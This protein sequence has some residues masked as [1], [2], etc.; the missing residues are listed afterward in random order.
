MRTMMNKIG[1]TRIALISLFALCGCATAPQPVCPKP[2]AELLRPG[3]VDFRKRLDQIL[4]TGGATTA[5]ISDP[6]S[7]PKPTKPTSAPSSVTR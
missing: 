2:P 1:W 3:A 5:P 4:A 7:T 6:R